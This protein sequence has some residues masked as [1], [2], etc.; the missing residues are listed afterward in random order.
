MLVALWLLLAA[1]VMLLLISATANLCLR[2]RAIHAVSDRLERSGREK[3]LWW[4]TE[5]RDHLSLATAALRTVVLL[6]LL[7]DIIEICERLGLEHA[8]RNVVSFAFAFVVVLLFGVAVPATI[9][10]YAAASMIVV[11]FPALRLL[12]VALFPFLRAWDVIDRATRRLLG[13]P[14]LTPESEADEMEKEIL[15]VVSEGQ[16]HGAVDEQETEMIRSIIEFGDTDVAEIM[17]PRT[18]IHAID[19]G[20][21]LN[22]AKKVIAQ[23]GHSRIPVYDGTIDNIL[24]V[25][26]AK[27]LLFVS[28]DDEF[29]LGKMMRKVP[30]IPDSKPAIELLQELK[31]RQVHIAIVLDEYGGTVGLVTIEDIIEEVVGEIADEYEPPETQPI[32]R[33]DEHTVEVDARMRI[34]ELNHELDIELPEHEDYETIGGYVFSSMGKI[35]RVGEQCRHGNIQINVIAAEPRRINR[36]RLHINSESDTASEADRA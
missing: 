24:G 13:A 3:D 17:T 7:L 28:N 5:V 12:H 15:N 9:A 19:R 29:D 27:D 25:L 36:L 22:D 2:T 23:S 14:A 20:T 1:L 8:R 18:D 26:Y 31:D 32:E 21:G 34:D 33:I 10:K 6:I 16:R 35:P 4:L 30:Y 11:A